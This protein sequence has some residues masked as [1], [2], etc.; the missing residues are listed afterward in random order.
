MAT[1]K[2]ENSSRHP[3]TVAYLRVSTVDQD[4]EKN[5][6]DI[7]HLANGVRQRFLRFGAIRDRP[8]IKLPSGLEC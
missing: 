1:R 2:K 5:R 3:K 7:L 6:A 4:I 8:T